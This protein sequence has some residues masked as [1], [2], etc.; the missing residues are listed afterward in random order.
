M[1]KSKNERSAAEPIMIL[2][3]SPIRVAVPPMFEA[4]ISVTKKGIG[5]ISSKSLQTVYVTG[6]IRRIV[7]TLSS[8]AESTAVMIVKASM[9]SQG[10]PF[11]SFADLIARYSKIPDPFT[12]PTN[13]II[14]TS[15][16]SVLKSIC[17]IPVSKSMIP[18]RISATA[19]QRAAV[20]RWIFSETIS[21]ITT[22]KM[23]IEMICA[24]VIECSV[25]WCSAFAFIKRRMTLRCS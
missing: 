20:V 18:N 21:A 17:S 16:P 14:P 9:I 7:V 25:C 11:T 13:N 24:V 12:T 23:T 5:L 6:P 4:R 19:P 10:L 3:G 2:G 8:S 1:M 15:T 22:T